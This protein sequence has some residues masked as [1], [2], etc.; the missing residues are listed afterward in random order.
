MD[1]ADTDASLAKDD[2]GHVLVSSPDE[3]SI[4]AGSEPHHDDVGDDDNNSSS[5]DDHNPLAF[6]SGEDPSQIF[7]AVAQEEL[8]QAQAALSEMIDETCSSEPVAT[9]AEH[10]P[11]DGL[12]FLLRS[13]TPAQA[14]IRQDSEHAS[15]PNLFK[16]E[17]GQDTKY[18][19]KV[20]DRRTNR[21][22]YEQMPSYHKHAMRLL[23]RGPVQRELLHTSTIRNF[24]TRETLRLGEA[25]DEPKS[26]KHIPAFVKMYQINLD[27]LLE[28]NL[29]MYFTFNEFFYRKLKPDARAIASPDDPDVVVS[30]ADCRLIT[31][32]NIS[33]A[34][35]IWIKGHQFSLRYLFQDEKLAK[36]FDGGSIGIFRLAPVDYHRFHSPIGGTI[37][38]HMKK[39]TGTYYTV[40]PIAIQEHI[41]VL[42]RNQRTVITINSENFE[43]VAFVAVG[44]LLVGSVNLT[45]SPYQ[46]VEKGDELGESKRTNLAREERHARVLFRLLRVRRQHDSGRVQSGNG[47]VG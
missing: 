12:A 40:N 15:A 20:L 1:R 28:P 25:F 8:C 22:I 13:M 35:R 5:N 26:R 47:Q 6:L 36:E 2:D 21:L 42:T 24:F 19:F 29:A 16:Y 18:A 37:G 44:A 14:T 17:D 10:T 27:E 41:D 43:R 46:T 30:A 23:F 45:V 33:E 4:V 7:L 32:D 38:E 3:Q 11:L 34:T 39:I 9:L 31:F